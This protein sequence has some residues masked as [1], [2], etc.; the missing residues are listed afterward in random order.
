M[1]NLMKKISALSLAVILTLLAI[2]VLPIQAT[3]TE[4]FYETDYETIYETTYKEVLKVN[5]N[6]DEHY[7]PAVQTGTE[8][9]V[10]ADLL[11]TTVSA[12]GSSV[13]LDNT[14][15]TVASDTNVYYGGATDL[16]LKNSGKVYAIDLDVKREDMNALFMMYVDWTG[17]YGKNGFWMKQNGGVDAYFYQMNGHNGSGM[18]YFGNMAVEDSTC[19]LRILVDSVNNQITI[20]AKTSAGTY[21]NVVTYSNLTFAS[22]NLNLMFRMWSDRTGKKITVS[23]VV[24]S[25]VITEEVKTRISLRY[26]LV[27]NANFNGDEHYN[28]AVQTGTEGLVGADLLTTT[29][30]ADGSSVVLDN[31]ASTVAS[32]TNVYYGGATD[33][34]LKNSGKVYAIDLDVKREDMNALFMMYV[35]WTGTYGKNGFWMKQ[36]GGVDAYFYQ[37]NG[38]NGSGMLYFGNMAV[39]DSTCSLRILVDSVNNQITIMA[40]TSAGTYENVVTYSNLTFA[41]ENLNL[42]FR[43]WS[44]RTGKKIT[45]SNLKVYEQVVEKVETYEEITLGENNATKAYLQTKAGDAAN[46]SDVRFLLAVDKAKFAA[47]DSNCLTVTFKKGDTTVATRTFDEINNTYGS[48][49]AASELKIAAEGVLMFGFIV[50]GVPNDAWDSVEVTFDSSDD[51][52]D[53]EGSANNA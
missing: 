45:V 32:D 21:E 38:H 37:M 35:D 16:P 2:P 17:T 23:N 52:I 34:P 31:T 36:N 14:A 24:I 3:E 50:T 46:T 40:K 12:D 29:V 15:S 9:L 19:S 41:S 53:F 44:D 33:L 47:A 39:E 11:T 5:F 42:M 27:L 1:K 4:S 7:N 26:D 48:V 6:G 49:Y 28:P 51:A 30:S 10:G 25:E 22:E 13:V 43:M 8:G 18:L 20:M